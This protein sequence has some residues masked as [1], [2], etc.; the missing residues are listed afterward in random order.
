MIK[1]LLL[2]LVLSATAFAGN[3]R[4]AV[5]VIEGLVTNEEKQ[6]LQMVHLYTVLGEE[7]AVTNN[8]GAFS[9]KSYQARP[10]KLIVDSK[11]YEG[12]T[13][14]LHETPSKLVIVLK[15]KQ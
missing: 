9:F 14:E 3:E 6:P 4:N 11:D 15:R 2:T 1:T 7:E 12:R 13:I 5:F 10:L 8:Q